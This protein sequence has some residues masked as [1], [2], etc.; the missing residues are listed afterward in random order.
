MA[1]FKK[2]TI[3]KNEKIAHIQHIGK[4]RPS[5]MAAK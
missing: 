2:L 1:D 5:S 4:W 3:L